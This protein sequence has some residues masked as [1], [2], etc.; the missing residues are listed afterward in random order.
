M[1][2]IAMYNKAAAL[3]SI[4]LLAAGAASAEEVTC[5]SQDNRRAECEMN[6][7]GEVRIVRQLSKSPCTEG[8]TWGLNKHSVWVEGGCRAVFASDGPPPMQAQAPRGAPMGGGNRVVCESQDNRRNECE[9]N[10]SGEVRISQQLSRTACIEGQTWGLN[11][12]TVW[13]EGGCR[14]EFENV[15]ADRGEPRRSANDE[16]TPAHIAACNR[17]IGG[18]AEVESFTALSPGAWDL[19]LRYNGRRYACDVDGQGRV[20]GFQQLN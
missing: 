16:P 10:T 17:R 19:I 12:H 14:A 3:A 18:E 7:R 13:V 1:K 6:T 8:V 11:R 5:E 2:R 20:D 9:M 15:S 4:L